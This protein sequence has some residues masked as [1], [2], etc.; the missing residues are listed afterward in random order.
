[1][2]PVLG[3]IPDVDPISLPS[4]TTI[5]NDSPNTSVVLVQTCDGNSEYKELFD[6]T[7]PANK[8]YAARHGYA[9]WTFEGVVR[10]AKP[11]HAA[12]N[13]IYLFDMAVK[14]QMYDWIFYLDNDALIV[15]HKKPVTDLLDEKCLII[16][17]PGASADEHIFDDF[18][19]GV[20]LVNLNHPRA[21]SM[22]KDWMQSYD[23]VSMETLRLEP[24]GVF[25]R[26]GGYADDQSMLQDLVRRRYGPDGICRTRSIYSLVTHKLRGDG[27]SLAERRL[28]L[29]KRAHAIPPH[30]LS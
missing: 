24:D 13:R 27:T 23:M 20:M 1:M 2:R 26:Q 22:I 16:V 11:W 25:D 28:E 14:A 15:N 30:R 17:A 8:K 9:Y 21:L 19:N 18:N 3:T 7:A 4:E 6:V 29:E 12:F 10:G 5:K